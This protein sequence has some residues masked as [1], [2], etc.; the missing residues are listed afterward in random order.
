MGRQYA[1]MN[2]GERE[3]NGGRESAEL[4]RTYFFNPPS[5]LPSSDSRHSPWPAFAGAGAGQGVLAVGS[6][7]D[8]KAG[9]AKGIGSSHLCLALV[10]HMHHTQRLASCTQLGSHPSRS[11]SGA[12]VHSHWSN[13]CP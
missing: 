6:A 3:K 8:E 4:T 5:S 2:Q 1:E 10:S 9:K 12:D 11:G 13:F 7:L